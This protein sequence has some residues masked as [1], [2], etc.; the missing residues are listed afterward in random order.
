MIDG[1]EPQH[2]DA[3]FLDAAVR[4]V[5]DYFW[6]HAR[7]ALRQ[8][9]LSERHANARKALRRIKGNDQSEMSVKDIHA[10]LPCSMCRT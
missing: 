6:P 7:A 5:R 8:I 3:Q 10:W 4:M 1:P 2:I 9:G